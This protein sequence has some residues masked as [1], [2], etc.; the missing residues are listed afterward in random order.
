VG[1]QQSEADAILSSV[2]VPLTAHKTSPIA[3]YIQNAAN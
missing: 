2:L 3:P 1:E